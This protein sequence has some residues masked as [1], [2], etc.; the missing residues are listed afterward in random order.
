LL[1]Q[2]LKLLFGVDYSNSAATERRQAL[3]WEV[4]AR[5][6]RAALQPMAEKGRH[7]EAFYRRWC[8][9][10]IDGTNSTANNTQEVKVRCRKARSRRGP[11]AFLKIP[12]VVLLELGLHN[13]LAVAIGRQ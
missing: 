13:P 8:L 2:H 6:L 4:F 10:A 9:V 3:P 1:S 11:A 5:L 7:G 12:A